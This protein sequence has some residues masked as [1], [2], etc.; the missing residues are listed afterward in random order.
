MIS[1]AADTR[2]VSHVMPVWRPRPEWL[3]A[4]ARNAL[5]QRGCQVELIVV[6]DGGDEPIAE[7]LAP[8]ADERVRIIR[9]EHGGPAT[10]RNAGIAIARGELIRFIDCDDLMATDSTARLASY[11]T[12]DNVIGYGQ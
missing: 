10:A 5:E 2:L 3:L 1:E 8:I 4:A 12:G 7:W 11:V 9:I 6:D